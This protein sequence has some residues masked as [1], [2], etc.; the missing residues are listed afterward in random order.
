MKKMISILLTILL[1]VPIVLAPTAQAFER[2]S[3]S[4]LMYDTWDH[5]GYE[6][7]EDLINADIFKGIEVD[8]LWYEFRPNEVIT[9]AQFAAVIVRS[10]GLEA[11]GEGETYSDIPVNHS[12]KKEIAIASDHGIVNGVGE[13]KFAPNEPVLREQVATIIVRAFGESIDF[14]IPGTK[15]VFHDVP[16]GHWASED[17]EKASRIELV[18]GIDKGKFGVGKRATRGEAAVLLHRALQ[19]EQANLPSDEEIISLVVKSEVER[20]RLVSNFD[21]EGY[22]KH[23]QTYFTGYEKVSILE[24]IDDLMEELKEIMSA[25]TLVF[26]FVK[27]PTGEVISKSDRFVQVEL[28]GELSIHYEDERTSLKT[29]E[30]YDSIY[31]L[32]KEN[33]TWKIYYIDYVYGFDDLF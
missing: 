1:L 26:E 32:K 25:D 27:E 6:E 21:S 29:K 11:T 14:T 24:D 12:L 31:Y 16:A 30:P 22:K 3:F 7:M 28:S 8:E 20:F 17:I 10:L 15:Q 23:I 9:R 4:Y 5:W 18:K 33:D 2:D 13:G 19:K